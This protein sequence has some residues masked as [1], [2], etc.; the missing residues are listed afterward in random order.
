MPTSTL[1]LAKQLIARPSVTPDDAGC[2]EL[3]QAELAP[4]GFRFE[5]TARNGVTNL[6]ARRGDTAPLVCLAGHTDVVPTGPREKWDSDPFVPTIRDG[7]LYG[8]GAADMKSSLAAFVTA[9]REL[10]VAQPNHRGSIAFLL[11]SDEEGPATDGT[12]AVIEKLLAR[13]EIPDFCIVGEPTSAQRAGDT[14]KNGRRGSLSG[15]LTVHGVQGHV[16]YPHQALNAVHLVSPAIAQMAQT[17]WDNGNDFFPPTTWQVSN[18]RAGTGAG[19]VIPGE[20]EVVFNFRFSTASTPQGLR[21]RVQQILAGNGVE[22]DVAWSL[23]AKP[24]LT[25]A[26]ALV[27]AVMG[28]VE[29]GIGIRPELSTTGGTS[30]GRFLAEICPNVI[31]LGPTNAT[32]HKVNEHVPLAD[33]D[34][35]AL[36]YRLTLE[37]LLR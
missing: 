21:E 4:L 29:Q 2:Q 22:G 30:D 6:W 24:Y 17:V 28:A 25:D 8:R 31:E 7:K 19:N 1:E 32:I 26:G 9:V 12:V 36:V 13:N 35:L 16:A 34:P 27:D 37:R 5:T 33:L 3:I 10:V 18:M 14:V 23:D 11:T 20:A 15:R